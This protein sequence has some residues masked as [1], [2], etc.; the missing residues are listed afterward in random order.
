MEFRAESEYPTLEGI[1]EDCAS[2]RVISPAYA[3]R[4]GELTAILQ[5]VYQS[6]VF[7]ECGFPEI[8]KRLVSIAVNE[9]RHLELLGTAICKLGAQP[10]FTACPP[11]PVGFYSAS[12]INYSKNP[13]QMLCASICGEENAI[14]EYERILCRL[15]NPCVSALI[16]RILEDEKV[17]LKELNRMFSIVC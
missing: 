9:M 16:A 14:A 17:H 15:K 6:I 12:N 10:V 3:G 7:E 11:Y 4:S 5:Y 2:I 1:G 8:S 13:R